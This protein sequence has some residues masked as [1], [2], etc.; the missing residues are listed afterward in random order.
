MKKSRLEYS[1]MNSGISTAIYIFRLV[2]QFIARSFFIKYLGNEYLGLNGLFTNILSLLSVAELGIGTSIIFSLYKPLLNNDHEKIKSLMI[3]Y[4]KAYEIIGILIGI[5]GLMVVPFLNLIINNHAHFPNLYLIYI[6]FL[7]NSVVSYFF[8]YK[9]SL[10]SADQRAYIVSLND[11]IFLVISNIIQII[12]LILTSNFVIYLL[13]QIIFTIISNIVI[14]KIVDKNYPYLSEKNIVKLDADT[15]TE[16]KRNVIGNFSSKVGGVI[17]MGTD[18]ILISLFLNLSAVGIYS[19]YTLII[20]SVQ[21]LC[22]QVT[23]SITA[24]IGNY[25]ITS[26]RDAGNRLFHRHFFINHTLIFFSAILLLTMINPFISWWIGGR[27]TLP[28]STVVLIVF[29]YAIQVYRNTSFAFI[30]SYGLF[31]YQRKK[32]IIEA[33]I[34]LSVSLVL[35]GVFKLGINGVLI[36]TIASSL[37]FVIWYEAFVIYKYALGKNFI[38]FIKLFMQSLFQLIISSIAVYLFVTFLIQSVKVDGILQLLL[39]GMSTVMFSG[40]I[41]LL[42]YHKRDEFKY[43]RDILKGLARRWTTR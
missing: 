16:I 1:F 31:W 17:V 43:L 2:L 25:A 20:N 23:N 9:R 15:V 10:I 18:N 21:N 34:N 14:S 28:L 8:T 30:E 29:N 22:K 37:G 36:G 42:L 39:I 19:N 12:F 27:F 41:Y 7:L 13:I 32:P 11:F 5:V 35:L 3:L 6:L 26:D 33:I 24:S 40:C 4:K 38:E